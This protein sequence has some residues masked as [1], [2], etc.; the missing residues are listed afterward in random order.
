MCL[1]A[2]VLPTPVDE[3]RA[4][5]NWLVTVGSPSGITIEPHVK[6]SKGSTGDANVRV[7]IEQ[8]TAQIG[9]YAS[10]DQGAVYI[11]NNLPYIVRLNQGWSA[12]AP[13]GFVE[14]GIAAARAA[15]QQQRLLS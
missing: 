13:A 5:S 14:I 3:G 1:Q 8:G 7:T 4:R 6:G 11:S 12:Q 15:A 10:P 2:I 9:T